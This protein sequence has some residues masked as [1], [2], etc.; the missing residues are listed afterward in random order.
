VRH[1]PR[2]AHNEGVDLPDDVVLFIARRVRE[3]VRELEGYLNRVII[4]LTLTAQLATL[5]TVRAALTPLLPR[6]ATPPP[7]T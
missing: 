1:H 7:R 2:K 4:Y 5:D 3:N 6:N